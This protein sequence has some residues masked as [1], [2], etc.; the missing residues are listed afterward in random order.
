MKA[1]L[2]LAALA[3]GPDTADWVT[4]PRRATVGDTVWLARHV[5]AP[6]GWKV[7]AGRLEGVDQI[8][9]LGDPAVLRT[10]GGWVVRYPV[11]VWAAGAHD[12]VLAPIWR[13]GPDGRTDSLP[14]GVARIEILTVIPDSVAHPEPQPAAALIRPERRDPVLLLVAIALSLGLGAAGV[15]WRRRAPRAVPADLQVPLEPHVPDRAWLLAG[16]PKAVAARAAGQLRAALAR[17]E[18]GAPGALAHEVEDVL[19][20]L[21]RVAFAVAQGGEVGALAA[22]AAALAR[23]LA[24]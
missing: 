13:L 14:G 11:A 18:A 15:R 9:P 12:V 19:S 7:R 6:P 5:T 10:S 21:D 17:A 24:P 16:E 22:R 23:Q 2:L 4:S 1:L 20:Q 8:E 3:Q